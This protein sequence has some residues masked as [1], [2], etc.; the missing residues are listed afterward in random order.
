M[1]MVAQDFARGEEVLL[2]WQVRLGAGSVQRCF[3]KTWQ[4]ASDPGVFL[5]GIFPKKTPLYQARSCWF[6]PGLRQD[7]GPVSSGKGVAMLES[8]PAPFL[9]RESGAV[10]FRLLG[11][12]LLG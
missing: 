11:R 5:Q 3:V 4:E 10:L 7:P 8:T 12:E 2:A 6:G 9:C 1:A